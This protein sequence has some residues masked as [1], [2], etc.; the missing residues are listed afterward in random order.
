MGQRRSNV[1]SAR[2]GRF[3][4]R[5]TAIAMTVAVVSALA[6]RS[7]P[8]DRCIVVNGDS[9]ALM[10]NVDGVARG[11]ARKYCWSTSDGARTVRFIVARRSDDAITVVLDACRVCY[12]NKLGYRLSRGGLICRFCGNRYSIDNLSIGKMSCLPFKLPFTIDRGRL[13]IRT[14][15]LKASAGFFPPETVV[16]KILWA[17]RG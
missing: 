4:L 2:R 12:L 13:K 3:R 8:S 11:T 17:H 9:A 6:W 14:S 1:K 16:D 7:V 5:L 10:L 15:D